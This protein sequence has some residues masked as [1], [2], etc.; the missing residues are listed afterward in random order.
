M[1]IHAYFGA[2]SGVDIRAPRATG[3]PWPDRP[4]YIRSSLYFQLAWLVDCT[5][6][7]G[8][9]EHATLIGRNNECL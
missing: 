2:S 1:A 7:I 5:S 4:S 8:R 3:A 6:P 9:V